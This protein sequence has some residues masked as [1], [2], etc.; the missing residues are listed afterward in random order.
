MRQVPASL[1]LS[2]PRCRCLQKPRTLSSCLPNSLGVVAPR[3]TT[4]ETLQK[5]RHNNHTVSRSAARAAAL[6]PPACVR[7]AAAG[8]NAAA[9]LIQ[10]VATSML[11]NSGG[12]GSGPSLWWRAPDDAFSRSSSRREEEDDEEA[13]RWAA[14]E[15]LPTG[16]RIHR[17]ILPLGG[18]D[19]DGGGEAAPQVVDVLGLGPRERRAL[20]ERLVRVA[21]EDN[22]RF[23][24]KIKERVERCVRAAGVDVDW[25]HTSRAC[26][27]TA[28]G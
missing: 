24:L 14:L 18:G 20:L 13:L 22:E 3:K 2:P 15:R 12:S 5:P 8:M 27:Y 23:L 21:D 19:C 1:P 4:W 28:L 6:S 9:E 16:D 7:S 17:A 25:T 26:S 11:G 10:K